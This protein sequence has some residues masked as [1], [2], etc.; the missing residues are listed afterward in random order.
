MALPPGYALCWSCSTSYYD[1]AIDAR[2]DSIGS[3][4]TRP[5]N[6]SENV[7]LDGVKVLQAVQIMDSANAVVGANPMNSSWLYILYTKGL[8]TFISF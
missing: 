4:K 6:A 7:R 2:L 5:E 1:T 3:E 8:S